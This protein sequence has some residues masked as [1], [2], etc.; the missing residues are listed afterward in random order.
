MTEFVPASW[1]RGGRR[2]R[3]HAFLFAGCALLAAVATATA[4]PPAG[5]GEEQAPVVRR[6]TVPGVGE[7]VE[8][9]ARMH[10]TLRATV[11]E[12]GK[13][14]VEGRRGAAP[15][16]PPGDSKPESE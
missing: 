5:S 13:V 4:E 10:H 12:R 11:D 3:A 16:A 2:R 7:M 6:G 1:V 8:V 14:E 15:V 9:P